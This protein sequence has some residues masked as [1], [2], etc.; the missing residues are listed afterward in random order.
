MDIKLFDSEL[1]IMEIL[2]KEG[3]LTAKRIAERTAEQIGW[4]KTTTYTVLKKCVEKG[5]I[6]RR[7]PNFVCHPL[8]TRAQAQQY[9]T[10]EL[11]DRMYDGAPDQL[12]AALLDSRT[13]SREEIDRLRQLIR[14]LE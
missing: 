11:I 9:E 14:D 13:L 6:E 4:S 5:A 3:D 7:E 8:I 10:R 2:W 12:V 1:K